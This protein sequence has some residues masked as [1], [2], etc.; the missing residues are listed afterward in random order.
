MSWRPR[1]GELVG[2]KKIDFKGS[3]I[4]SRETPAPAIEDEK[5]REWN[6]IIMIA[7]SL[8]RVGDDE[9]ESNYLTILI[10][11]ILL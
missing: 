8:K 9:E 11:F 10:V 3:V 1:A 5:P 2:V 6:E 4:E 7:F